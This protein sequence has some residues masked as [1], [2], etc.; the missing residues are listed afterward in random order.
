MLSSVFSNL[1]LKGSMTDGP[2][3][4]GGGVSYARRWIVGL[5][6]TDGIEFMEESENGI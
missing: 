3:D 6:V 1:Y 5:A 4:F 2:G